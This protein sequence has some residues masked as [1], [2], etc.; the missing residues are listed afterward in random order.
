MSLSYFNTKR[1]LSLDRLPRT[2]PNAIPS[3]FRGIVVPPTIRYNILGYSP[4]HT[5]TH[6]RNNERWGC[7]LYASTQRLTV[8]NDLAI[9]WLRPDS[10]EK[11]ELT[12]K[13][14]RSQHT[15]H[16][17]SPHASGYRNEITQR[18][19]RS[20]VVSGKHIKN[21][22]TFPAGQRKFTF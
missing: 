2:T 18:R 9:I 16:T 21:T 17:Q 14:N 12:T 7:A 11:Q 22:L 6:A 19:Q 5:H 10:D 15:H 13:Y 20:A 3:V 1:K 4:Q 8:H